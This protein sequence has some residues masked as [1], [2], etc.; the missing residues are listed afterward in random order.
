ML[1]DAPVYATLAASEIGRA[2]RWYEEKLEMTPV[3][4]MGDEGLIYRSGG[5][6]FSIYKSAGAGTARN[7]VATIVVGDLDAVVADLRGRGVVFEDY[8]MGDEGPTTTDGVA[9]DPNGGKAA[10]FK[11]SEDNIVALAQLPPGMMS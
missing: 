2:R 1:K 8:A 11:D 6:M 5:A 10:W 9:S 7:T 4:D 3:V